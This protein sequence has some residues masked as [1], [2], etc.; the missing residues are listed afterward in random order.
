MKENDTERVWET[1][2]PLV[3]FNTVLSGWPCTTALRIETADPQIG[4]T[5]LPTANKQVGI[6]Y[7]SSR[8][9]WRLTHK[10]PLHGVKLSHQASRLACTFGV[11]QGKGIHY[12]T[13]PWGQEIMQRFYLKTEGKTYT[14]DRIIL[15]WIL[16]KHTYIGL[17]IGV[18]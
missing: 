2:V 8:D 7:I 16:I 14:C 11:T 9:G 5:V 6:P 3:V 18:I 1:F 17:N 12:F 4:R 10:A 15:K 13:E